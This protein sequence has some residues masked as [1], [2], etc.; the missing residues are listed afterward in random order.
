M[1]I[2][3]VYIFLA[4]SAIF[5]PV[6]SQSSPLVLWPTGSGHFPEAVYR[7][8][9][10]AVLDVNLVPQHRDFWCWAAATEMISTYHGSRVDQ[11]DSANFVHG[12]PPNCCTGCSGDCP[13]WGPAWAA[14]IAQI[15]NNWNHWNYSFSY[16]ARALTWQEL[17]SAIYPIRSPVFAAWYWTGGG[18]HVVVARGYELLGDGS[19]LVYVL[20]PWAPDCQPP[21]QTPSGQPLPCQPQAGGTV[22]IMDYPTF[23]NDRIHRWGDSLHDFRRTD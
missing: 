5:V 3:F 8:P 21:S 23:V 9:A 1:T 7:Q 12:V 15:Q 18:G 14:S 20:D 22:S 2:R 11:C 13:G 6:C 19:R 4:C 17:V 16:E 10:I